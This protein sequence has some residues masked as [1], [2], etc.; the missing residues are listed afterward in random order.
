MAKVTMADV[1]LEA[2]VNKATVSRALKG[3]SRIS[4]S[5][6]EKVWEAAK[7]LGYRVDTVAQGLSSRKTS[8]VGI[9]LDDLRA[10][11]S[12]S[13][14]SGVEKV[15]SRYRV[16]MMVKESGGGEMSG[17]SVFQR[18]LDRKVDGVIWNSSCELPDKED[19]PCVVI[20][21]AGGAPSSRVVYDDRGISERILTVAGD[22]SIKYIPGRNPLFSFL[23]R[24]ERASGSGQLVIYDGDLPRLCGEKKDGVV[25]MVCCD[26]Y[27]ASRMGCLCLDWLAFE[28][29]GVAARGIMNLIR[30]KGVR[31]KEVFLAPCVYDQGGYVLC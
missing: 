3:D 14:L 16:E 21:N 25:E 7:K 29:G 12:G 30:E 24:I 6:R 8:L 31:A 17:G 13:F 19:V 2:N 18:L 26:P 23:S 15:L 22:R 5:T 4:P 27:W 1:A 11:W 10:P 20:G 28:A 9:A